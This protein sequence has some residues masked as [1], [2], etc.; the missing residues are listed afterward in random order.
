MAWREVDE[1][2]LAAVISQREIDAFRR[3]GSI[4]GSDPVP[5]LIGDNVAEARDAIATNGNVRLAPGSTLPAGCIPA[6]MEIAA[7]RLLKRISVNPNEARTAAF[8][9]AKEFFEKIADGKRTCESYGAD[10]TATTGGPAIEVVS[11]VRDRVS[12]AKLEGL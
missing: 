11:T 1:S 6:A 10:D 2:D 8:R 3:D 9:E 4:D 7:Y 5:K 12:A